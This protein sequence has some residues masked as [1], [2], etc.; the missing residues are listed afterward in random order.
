[1]KIAIAQLNPLIGDISGN[2]Q[3]ILDAALRLS[4]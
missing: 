4:A 1:M 3:R 2:V